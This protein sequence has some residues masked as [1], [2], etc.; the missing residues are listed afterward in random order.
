MRNP[1][2]WREG[3]RPSRLEGAW[4]RRVRW[5]RTYSELFSNDG[6]TSKGQNTF[7][8]VMM[9]EEFLP[10]TFSC[11]MVTDLCPIKRRAPVYDMSARRLMV[12]RTP[13]KKKLYGRLLLALVLLAMQSTKHEV[14]LI[15]PKGIDKVAGDLR[16][17]KMSKHSH[18][19]EREVRAE[20]LASYYLMLCFGLLFS[21]LRS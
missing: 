21:Y 2:A 6:K 14:L 15:L 1:D 18:Q 11:L 19:L 12:W 9:A 4:I 8:L 17:L 13:R 7:G 3:C 5:M 20:N 10:R 16:E